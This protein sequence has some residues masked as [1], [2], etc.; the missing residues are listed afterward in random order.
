MC[1]LASPQPY[2]L[3]C[4]TQVYDPAEALP[5]P[6]P[7]PTSPP[8]HVRFAGTTRSSPPAGGSSFAS[9]DTNGDGVV[10]REEW[11]AAHTTP[12]SPESPLDDSLAFLD[13]QAS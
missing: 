5:D 10:D 1:L 13:Q 4:P 9:A 3:F 11:A 12:E 7:K 2:A 8:P 6:K